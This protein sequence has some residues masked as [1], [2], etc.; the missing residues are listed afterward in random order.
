MSSRR[1]DNRL[2]GR[3]KEGGRRREG[4]GDGLVFPS[5]LGSP[6]LCTWE[7]F[8]VTAIYPQETQSKLIDLKYWG[9]IYFISKSSKNVQVSGLQVCCCSC[10]TNIIAIFYFVKALFINSFHYLQRNKIL[11]GLL[12]AVW[13]RAVLLCQ[14]K[15]LW[16]EA[17]KETC[18]FPVIISIP[19]HH[20]KPSPNSSHLSLHPGVGWFEKKFFFFL[21]LLSEAQSSYFI[22]KM[23]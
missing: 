17:S 8:L 14:E 21:I 13:D 4:K 16:V 7:G 12:E 19:L 20:P 6:S 10:S 11:W 18:H 9:V 15:E 22:F 23:A 5:S 2:R 1:E 3:R